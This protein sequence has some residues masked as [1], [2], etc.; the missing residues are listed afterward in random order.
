ML[1]DYGGSYQY[2]ADNILVDPGQYGIAICG[3]NNNSIV[4]NL[5]YGKS[6]FFTNVGLFTSTWQGYMPTKSTIRGNKVNYTNSKNQPNHSWAA[7]GI[8]TPEGWDT[9]VFGAD[10]NASILPV[11]IITK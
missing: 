11:K 5:I 6:Q 8:A 10:I 4:N 9:N 3:G 2:A 7:P 1:G